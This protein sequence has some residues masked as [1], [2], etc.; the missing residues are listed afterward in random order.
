MM[1]K[2]FIL[3]IG[4][5]IALF[6]SV[7]FSCT[8]ES[9]APSGPSDECQVLGEVQTINGKTMECKIYDYTTETII[10][11][12]PDESLL[13]R[14]LDYENYLLNNHIYMDQMLPALMD[15]EEHVLGEEHVVEYRN[16]GDS[17]IWSGTY[18][19][20]QAMRYMKTKNPKALENIRMIVQG[21]HNRF[22]IAQAITGIP[23]LSARFYGIHGDPKIASEDNPKPHRMATSGEWEGYFFQ[24]NQSTDQISGVILGYTATLDATNDAEI[25]E[26]I[27][28]DITGMCDALME[29]EDPDTL[30]MLRMESINEEDARSFFDEID[31]VYYLNFNLDFLEN[32]TNRDRGAYLGSY[33]LLAYKASGDQK[34]LDFYNDYLVNTI[35]IEEDLA[36]WNC[37]MGTSCA[38]VYEHYFNN[39]IVMNCMYSLLK[40]EQYNTDL[41]ETYQEIML[42]NFWER[43]KNDKNAWFGYLVAATTGLEEAMEVGN[44]QL[45]L[46]PAGPRRV[47][48]M[49]LRG[50]EYDTFPPV[51]LDVNMRFGIGTNFIWQ[52]EQDKLYEPANLLYEYH[53]V[54]Y[55]CIYWMARYY[56]FIPEEKEV[57]LKWVEV[58]P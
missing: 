11:N 42:N 50:T 8:E 58:Q 1:K 31:G 40:L 38:P 24:G 7:M 44:R 45:L 19:F 15:T 32:L 20:S 53:G 47:Y 41:Q 13:A 25:R 30:L 14:A 34:Y 39:N 9:I 18:L 28:Q 10:E 54:D 37:T 21:I 43:L 48:G 49:D 51:P 5:F 4:S 36:K 35:H 56:D 2:L 46:F 52:R 26:M 16:G 22:Q 29:P 33:F 27:R 3:V 23:G 17:C 12:D 6:F 57:Y 55:L